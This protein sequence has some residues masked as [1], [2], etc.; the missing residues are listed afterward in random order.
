MKTATTAT[1]RQT[2][3]RIANTH[4]IDAALTATAAGLDN[5]M[6]RELECG[7]QWAREATAAAA[8]GDREAFA[9]LVAEF[10]QHSLEWLAA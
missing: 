8:S 4:G 6:A 2:L 1:V 9:A 3:N 5:I 10:V 7:S